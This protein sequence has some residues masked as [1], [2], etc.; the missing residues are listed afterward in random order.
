MFVSELALA[1]PLVV[2]AASSEPAAPSEPAPPLIGVPARLARRSATLEPS[3]IVWAAKL[4]RYLVVSDDTGPAKHHH[5]PWVLAMSRDGVFDAEPVPLLGLDE[6]N[7]AES[8]CAGP[9]GLFF[10]VTSHSLNRRGLDKNARDMLLLL[11][12]EGRG[13]SVLGRLDLKTARAS[14]GSGSLLS[15]AGLPADG[16]LD[17]EAITYRDGALLVGLKSPLSAH[18]GA[19]VLAFANPVA[20]LRAGRL[21]PGAI[22]RRWEIAL[23]GAAGGVPEGIADL[24][25]LPDGR[26]AVL[27]NSPKG[28]ASDHGGSLYWFHPDTGGVTFVRQWVGFHPEGITLA[29]DGKGLVIVFDANTEPPRWTRWPLPALGAP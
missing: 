16:R 20:A 26:I 21:P 14:D 5:E 25:T 1:L 9:N 3:G 7:D 10:L 11:G 12:L 27:A 2:A 22:T 19:V 29:A 15:R 13:L 23:H 6:L 17:I 28:R 18:D 4:D 8:I 24:T